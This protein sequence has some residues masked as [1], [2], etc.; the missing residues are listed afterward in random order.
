EQELTTLEGQKQQLAT[1]LSELQTQLTQPQQQKQ[2]LEQELTTLEGQKQQLEAGL[3]DLEAQFTAQYNYKE[4][5]DQEVNQLEEQRR[6]LEEALR[7]YPA[8]KQETTAAETVTE[9]LLLDEDLPPEWA[10]FAALQD[11]FEN[12][13]EIP[14]EEISVEWAGMKTQESQD[15]ELEDD[16]ASVWTEFILALPKH[17]LETL[18]V[19]TQEDDPAAKLGSIAQ[20]NETTPEE[21]IKVINGRA[22]SAIGNQ[23]I[24]SG[25]TSPTI[26]SKEYSTILQQIFEVIEYMEQ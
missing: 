21:L 16:L 25:S 14:T 4:I 3:S 22:Q 13:D 26:A 1:E 19:I 18:K 9:A 12:E 23:I 8:P 5:L 10:A 17:Q 20:E 7:E 2:Q 24:E 11:K 15:A 6:Q